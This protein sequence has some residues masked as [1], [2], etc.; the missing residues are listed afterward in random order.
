MPINGMQSIFEW[1]VELAISGAISLQR[2]NITFNVEKGEENPFTTTL[3]LSKTKNGVKCVLIARAYNQEN[4][5]D[6]AVYFVGQ[7]LDVLSLQL[8]IPLHLDFFRPEFREISNHVKRIINQEEWYEAFHLGRNYSLNRR[9]FSRALSWYRKGLVS[10]DPIDRLVAFWSALESICSKFY[11]QNDRTDLGIINKVCNCF[12]Q[13]WDNSN[14]WKIIPNRPEI[15]NHFYD[16]RNGFSHGFLRVDIENIRCLTLDLPI[17]QNL[18]R[19]FLLDWESDGIE[20]ENRTQPN[21][22][23]NS[24]QSL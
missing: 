9:Y 16:F 5:N 19:H 2:N 6:V 3:T 4:A 20:I 11:E 22:I 8:D 24:P 1:E 7:A 12:D 18:V 14:N 13:I 15:I 10:D 17:Y 21:S 23:E